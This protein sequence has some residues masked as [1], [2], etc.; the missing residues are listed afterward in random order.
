MI[1]RSAERSPR[2]FGLGLRTV[3]SGRLPDEARAGLEGRG[4]TSR[5]AP[6]PGPHRGGLG[7][8]SGGSAGRGERGTP[9]PYTARPPE[10]AAHEGR[11]Y[12]AARL[13]Q[14]F[15]EPAWLAQTEGTPRKRLGCA[16]VTRR[17]R[18]LAPGR[19]AV[20]TPPTIKH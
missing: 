5:L 10:R 11:S 17:S 12:G 9:T 14:L 7:P 1:R 19:V 18:E 8:G 2:A 20:T 6:D 3:G 15:G 16:Q 13:V 4:C